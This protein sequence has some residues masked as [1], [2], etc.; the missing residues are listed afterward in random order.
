MSLECFGAMVSYPPMPLIA[1][2]IAPS[3]FDVMVTMQSFGDDA[4][5]PDTVIAA[6]PHPEMCPGP[7]GDAGFSEWD[8][9]GLGQCRPHRARGVRR[10]SVKPELLGR[11]SLLTLT[12]H[13]NKAPLWPAHHRSHPWPLVALPESGHPLSGKGKAETGEVAL[14]T[15]DSYP[16]ARWSPRYRCLGCWVELGVSPNS[17][18]SRPQANLGSG[19][20][21]RG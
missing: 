6:Q 1:P 16:W 18:I 5:P 7:D 17:G 21:A 13:T 2:L 10:P 14:E 9:S 3:I 11:A 4:K 15:G 20:A 12:N 8:C 19:V